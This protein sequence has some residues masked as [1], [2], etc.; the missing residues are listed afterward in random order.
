MTEPTAPDPPPGRTPDPAGAGWPVAGTMATA[1][2]RTHPL[3]PAVEAVRTVGVLV[4]AMLVFGTGMV[5][6]AASAAGGLAGVLLVGLVALVLLGLAVGLHWLG[7]SRTRYF[8]DESGDFRLDSGVLQRN[9]RRVTLSR[10]QS[11]DVVRPLLGRV[12]GLAQVRVEVAGGGDSRVV[13]SYLAEAEAVALRAEIIARAAGM[14]PDVGEAP[15]VVLAAVP[16]NDLVMSLL[17]RSSTAV[18]LAVS[19]LIV[20][21]A[22]ATEGPGGLGLLLLTGGLPIV[23]VFTQFMRFFGFTVAESP[24]GLRLRHGLASVES[25]TVP[26]GRVQAI[27]I[28]EPLLWRRRGWVRVNLNVAGLRSGGEEAQVEQ[29]L[30]PVAPLEVALAIVGRVL[31]GVRLS[32]LMLEPAPAAARRRAWLQF[33]NLGVGHDAMVLAT[34]RGFLTR[35]TAVLP[36]ARTQSVRVTQGPWQRALG[37]ASVAVDSTPGPVAVVALHRAAGQARA[38]AEAQ[39]VRAAA[40]RADGSGGRWMATP[41]IPPAPDGST[42]GVADPPVLPATAPDPDP[43]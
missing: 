13:L 32:D 41:A 28:E 6:E 40:A 26:P 11:V 20:V 21:A 29:V 1:P 2:R 27:E 25:Q 39:L 10:L 23:G 19:V 9:Q 3:T 15:E 22:V 37:L 34:R 4:A 14:R 17:L 30:L 5:R 24:D 43:T 36:H 38:I 31:P 33:A 42:S 8:F 18:L 12:V 7:W 35:R 16:T